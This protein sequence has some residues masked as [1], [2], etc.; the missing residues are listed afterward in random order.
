MYER[1]YHA[2]AKYSMM[3]KRMHSAAGSRNAETKHMTIASSMM[4]EAMILT[5][6]NIIL[7]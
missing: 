6:S 3:T 7:V 4:T 1:E 5:R 2:M